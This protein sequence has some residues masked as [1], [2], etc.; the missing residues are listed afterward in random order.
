MVL[1]SMVFVTCEDGGASIEG[2][3]Y[4]RLGDGDGLLLH[5]LVNCHLGLE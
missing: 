3:L 4:A 2:C 5:C 1:I